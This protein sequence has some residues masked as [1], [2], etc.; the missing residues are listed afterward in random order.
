MP[1][2]Y[3]KLASKGLVACLACGDLCEKK[4][5]INCINCEDEKRVIHEHCAEKLKIDMSDFTC[6]Q[7]T[8]FLVP[9]AR[10]SG[11]VRLKTAMSELESP[12]YLLCVICG[13]KTGEYVINAQHDDT[14][15]ETETLPCEHCEDNERPCKYRV[16]KKCWNFHKNLLGGHPKFSC[17]SVKIQVRRGTIKNL[18]DLTMPD[19]DLKLRNL[20]E[21]GKLQK[22]R[23]KRKKRYVNAEEK[24][25]YCG[26]MVPLHQNNHLLQ[27]CTGI[28]ATP[29]IVED[30][31]DYEALAKRAFLIAKRRLESN[32]VRLVSD[33]TP[34]RA[35]RSAWGELPGESLTEL[36]PRSKRPRLNFQ[37]NS[38]NI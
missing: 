20:R 3:Q 28:N 18:S 30:I 15:Y 6:E 7:I 35:R 22:R 21:C 37:Q 17:A 23:C 27:H 1:K 10:G 24:C 33:T 4:R 26:K 25:A 29:V 9:T 34:K 8:E 11:K 16:H 38:E 12:P 13:E 36:N 31:T 19:S 32:T 14:S 5:G 2:I